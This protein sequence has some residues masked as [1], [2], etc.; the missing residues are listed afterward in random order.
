MTEVGEIR[1]ADQ[2]KEDQDR[3]QRKLSLEYQKQIH[4]YEAGIEPS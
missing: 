1:E 4:D 2:I 3:R